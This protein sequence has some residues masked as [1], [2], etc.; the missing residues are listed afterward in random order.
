[1]VGIVVV[2]ALVGAFLFG[3]DSLVSGAAAQDEGGPHAAAT[4]TGFVNG[5]GSLGAILQG[6]VTVQVS[7]LWG[8][9]ALFYVFVGLAVLAALCLLPSLRRD[10]RTT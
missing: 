2:F 5:M 3:P 1:M 9:Q 7:R 4:A 6:V 8:W 10:P